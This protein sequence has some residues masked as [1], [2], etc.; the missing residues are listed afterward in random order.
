MTDDLETVPHEA[1]AAEEL[2]LRSQIRAA[3]DSQRA[4]PEGETEEEREER[5]EKTRDEKGRFAAKAAEADA[6]PEEIKP[7]PETQVAPTEAPKADEALRPPPGW[8]PAAKVAFNALPEEVKAA[9]AQREAEVNKGFAKLA[10]FKPIERFAEMARSSGTT[11]D[12]ALER[13]T[14]MEQTLR[15]DPIAG[16]EAMSKNIG[17][18]PVQW[19]QAVLARY[20]GAANQAAAGEGAQG[21]QTPSGPDLSPIM[22]EVSQLKSYIAQQQQ[23]QVQSEIQKFA[24]DPA[25]VF[26][27]NVRPQMAQ[28]IQAGVASDFK[29]A[30]DKAC[31]AN[32]E[33]RGLLIKQQAGSGQAVA[34]K[35]VAA[36]SQARAAA[37]ATNGAPSPGTSSGSAPSNPN[38]SL[39]E[40]IIAARDAQAARA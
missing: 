32:P 18:H 23:Q 29:D 13:Y 20:G 30:Y 5:E 17:V 6:K 25:H 3:V 9:V 14:N 27:E 8:N 35:Q 22:A 7:A 36:V 26:F 40:T 4:A 2:D 12:Q 34:A 39:R 21:Y 38:M 1:E 24:S 11:L 33:I 15:R 31:W 19:A 37:R 28:L 10:E 16:F